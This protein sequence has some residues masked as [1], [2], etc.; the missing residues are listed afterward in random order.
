MFSNPLQCCKITLFG[1]WFQ[2]SLDTFV[3]WR[4]YKQL[5]TSEIVKAFPVWIWQK[6]DLLLYRSINVSNYFANLSLKQMS[7]E[8]KGVMFSKFCRENNTYQN[9]HKFRMYDML[10][11][12]R[13]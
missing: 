7:M 4:K 13:H 11:C 6:E 10:S 3:Q 12:E 5:Y 1:L 9:K 8:R 2:V